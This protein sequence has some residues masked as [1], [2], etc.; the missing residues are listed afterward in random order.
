MGGAGCWEE[1]L[2]GRA[3]D[4]SRQRRQRSQ[5]LLSFASNLPGREV[6]LFS[7]SG[8]EGD[9][10]SRTAGSWGRKELRTNR[11]LQAVTR[12][13]LGAASICSAA[14][15]DR[16]GPLA[17]VAT[18]V[19]LPG[20]LYLSSLPLPL[21]PVVLLVHQTPSTTLFLPGRKFTDCHEYLNVIRASQGQKVL[22]KCSKLVESYRLFWRRLEDR[23]VSFLPSFLPEV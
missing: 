20:Q 19:F 18:G 8:R 7:C 21:L 12:K 14:T 15:S 6:R 11:T 3:A 13:P 22:K 2:E 10:R 23:R 4:T 5:P 17:T 16:A 1:G 9:S